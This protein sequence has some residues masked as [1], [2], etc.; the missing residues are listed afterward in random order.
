MAVG[1]L[2][3]G[4]LGALPLLD[5]APFQSGAGWW[6]AVSA[7]AIPGRCR[8]AFP[9]VQ[10]DGQS[11]LLMPL[12]HGPGGRLSALV[13]PY[14]CLY[15]PVAAPSAELEPAV[16]ALA[17]HLGPVLRIDAID[18]AW[19]GWAAVLRGFRRAGYRAM[20]FASFGNWYE[21]LRNRRWDA[22]LADRPGALR[23]TIRRRLR[24]AERDSGLFFGL[25]GPGEAASYLADYERVHAQSWKQPEPF[26][27]FAAAFV[28]EAASAGV[29]RMAVLRRDGNPLAAQ[30]WTV[31]GGVATVLKLAHVEAARNDSPGTVLTAWMIRQLVEVERVAVLDF[32]RGDDPYKSHWATQRRQR[33]GLI[34]A[35]PRRPR[36]AAA[37]LRQAASRLAGR[38]RG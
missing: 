38:L 2:A 29:L 11:V 33:S 37:L 21:P 6:R 7:T 31:E 14:T 36:G 26:P 19:T 32:G 17:R 12:L 10:R 1:E 8:P 27:A 24:R 13:T 34:I 3:P 16:E 23:E 30:Y 18:P 15:Q 20:L 35:D 25:A 28:A 5:G 9:V 4:Q 22:Y